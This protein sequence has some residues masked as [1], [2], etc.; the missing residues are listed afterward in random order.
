MQNYVCSAFFGL[1]YKNKIFKHP[2]VR[3]S[4]VTQTIYL[5][6]RL[7]PNQSFK[8][9]LDIVLS[10]EQNSVNGVHIVFS[11]TISQ[12]SVLHFTIKWPFF[13]DQGK[14]IIMIVQILEKNTEVYNL[15]SRY[16][17]NQ[18]VI[19]NNAPHYVKAEV[20]NLVSVSLGKNSIITLLAYCN[21][22]GL[23][24]Y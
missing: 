12:H 1:I 10:T 11:W 4:K 9:M 15:R 21:S 2:I 17:V 3:G 18:W 24:E 16:W 22:G 5:C 23:K 20:G 7:C 14:R 6:P 19:L 8:V 13:K